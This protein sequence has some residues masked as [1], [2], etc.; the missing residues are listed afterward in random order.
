[1]DGVAARA[2]IVPPPTE[3]PVFSLL[4]GATAAPAP[5][6]LDPVLSAWD[7]RDL[8]VPWFSFFSDAVAAADNSASASSVSS[9]VGRSPFCAAA[10]PALPSWETPLAA[11]AATAAAAVAAAA[12][13][14]AA[15]AAAAAA[16]SA[17]AA[18]A[19]ASVAVAGE[20]ASSSSE[21]VAG[22]ASTLDPDSGWNSCLGAVVQ[23]L[24]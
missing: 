19:A 14:S 24:T 20:V 7:S 2:R 6:L 18:A 8:P 5:A 22:S 12:S 11:A 21:A 16:A 13:A 1:M 23:S 3:V 17:S 9:G 4:L 10:V 15:T